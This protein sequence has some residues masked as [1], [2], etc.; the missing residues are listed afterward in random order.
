MSIDMPYYAKR[1]R[2]LANR[3][4]ESPISHSKFARNAQKVSTK[5]PDQVLSAEFSAILHQ[6]QIVK[7]L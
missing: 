7:G 6:R 3:G 4:P 1:G 5:T 2:G